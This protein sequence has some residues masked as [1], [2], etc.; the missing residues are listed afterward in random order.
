MIDK[1]IENKASRI[2]G[3]LFL[4]VLDGT[5]TSDIWGQDFVALADTIKKQNAREQRPSE[6]DVRKRRQMYSDGIVGGDQLAYR[7]R[8]RRHLDE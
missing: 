8:K 4:C 6:Q 1:W 3:G 2:P 5:V 7:L